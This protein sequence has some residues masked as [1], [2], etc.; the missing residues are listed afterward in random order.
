MLSALNSLFKSC[1][2]KG[3]LTLY[4]KMH[5]LTDKFQQNADPNNTVRNLNSNY[6]LD[7][8]QENRTQSQLQMKLRCDLRH[9]CTD[10]E[11][12]MRLIKIWK[13]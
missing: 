9:Y 4:N 3:K 12:S 13:T 8:R 7:S 1:A 2:S 11:S 6:K 5:V 10:V